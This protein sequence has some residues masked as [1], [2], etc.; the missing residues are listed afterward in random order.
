[1]DLD[2]LVL[3]VHAQDDGDFPRTDHVSV[4]AVRRFD[5]AVELRRRNGDASTE[6][7]AS[8]RY[9]LFFL[10]AH[11]GEDYPRRARR[12]TE[13]IH[14]IKKNAATFCSAGKACGVTA[15][16]LAM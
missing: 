12:A 1:F 9:A 4:S 7:E 8:S 11:G 2:A 6:E 14:T 3:A 10:V 5:F 16:P 13:S 15:P